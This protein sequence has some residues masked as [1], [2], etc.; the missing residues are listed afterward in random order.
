MPRDSDV[1]SIAIT[2]KKTDFVYASA[3]SGVYRSVNGAQ[4]WSR[5]RLLPDRFTVRA[6]IVVIDPM[7]PHTAY[8]GTTEGL[9]ASH[10]DGQSWTRLTSAKS[11]SMR[12]RWIHEITGEYS[13][14]PNIRAF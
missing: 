3:C 9:F 5:L 2:R 7:D 6:Q 12:F 1:F 11:L 8:V 14:A 10:N 4:S 13:S